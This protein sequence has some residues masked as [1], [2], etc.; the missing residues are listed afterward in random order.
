M[1]ET[2]LLI[3][4][5]AALTFFT[6]GVLLAPYTPIGKREIRERVQ[7]ERLKGQRVDQ[8]SRAPTTTSM[9]KHLMARDIKRAKRAR[10]D[11]QVQHLKDIFKTC[12]RAIL[13]A[14]HQLW[15]GCNAIGDQCQYPPA[16]SSKTLDEWE[17]HWLDSTMPP[18]E[19]NETPDEKEANRQ[20]WRTLIREQDA[21]TEFVKRYGYIPDT[22]KYPVNPPTPPPIVAGPCTATTMSTAA[23]KAETETPE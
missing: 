17:D 2:S 7:D 3:Y 1:I 22:T 13:D 9:A 20:S 11:A 14:L 15:L 8:G 23:P 6:I 16:K 5:M 10:N 12:I 18:S 4:A 21:I 19:P